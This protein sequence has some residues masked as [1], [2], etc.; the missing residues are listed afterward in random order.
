MAAPAFGTK[1]NAGGSAGTSFVPSRPTS[2]A[3]G[4]I[5]IV[6][7]SK[8]NTDA[9]TWP[10]GWTI[11]AE[12]TNDTF[13]LGVGWKRASSE[14][15][16]WTWSWT[17][18]TWRDG[19]VYRYTGGVSSGSP[20]DPDPPAA[21][22]H[23]ASVLSIATNSNTTLTAN[24]VR[25]ALHNS[26]AIN[27]W[28]SETAGYTIRQN[29]ASNEI[30]MMDQAFVGPGSTGTA[31]AANNSP[32]GAMKAYMIEIASVAASTQDAPELR[33]RPDGLRGQMQMVQLLAQ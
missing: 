15:T 7:L 31:S 5:L 16:S 23:A 12:D 3:D 28:G 20:I 30:H 4:E 21:I 10:S 2:T 26:K 1:S 29:T 27:A 14:P 17:N 22:T 9:V 24:T 11:L 33:G 8:D 18:S 13:Y 6:E 19:A 25:V 32:S